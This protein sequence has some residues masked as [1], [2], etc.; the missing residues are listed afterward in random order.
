MLIAP[1]WGGMIN[2]LVTLR[3][4]WDKVRDSAMLKFMVVAVTAYG[5]STFEGP[6]LSLKTVNAI[7][8]FT[9]WTIAHVHIGGMGWN[10]FLTFGMLYWLLPKLFRT[11]LFSNKL[12]NAHF[13]I[14]T[15]GMLM[16]SVPLYW[17]GFTQTLMWKEFTADG[18]LAY[19]NFLE[20]VTQIIPM[21]MTNC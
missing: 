19:P 3:G 16:Y 14:A 2:G 4:A 7:S 5:L 21:Y 6:M 1:S 8:H 11:K 20:T 13:W 10:G 17:A 18:L 9:D 12:A 15:L